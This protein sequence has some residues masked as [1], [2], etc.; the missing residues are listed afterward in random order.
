MQIIYNKKNSIEI[1]A[2]DSNTSQKENFN[3]YETETHTIE[4]FL[5][6]TFFAWEC[7]TIY[8]FV[9]YFLY[10]QLYQVEIPSSFDA[11]I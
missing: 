6:G 10:P 4:L 9:H 8:Y 11:L 2:I 1:L 3:G 5:A 7:V